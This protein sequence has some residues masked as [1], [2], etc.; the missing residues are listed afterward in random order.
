MTVSASEPDDEARSVPEPLVELT[1][2]RRDD[3]TEHE[4]N[5]SSSARRPEVANALVLIP[6]NAELVDWYGDAN[7]TLVFRER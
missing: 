7:I 1:L 6:A 4:L 2:S 5:L 3:V